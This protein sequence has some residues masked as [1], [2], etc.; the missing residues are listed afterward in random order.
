MVRSM[1]ET[2]L[3]RTV[4]LSVPCADGQQLDPDVF[5]AAASQAAW[6]RSASVV[7]TRTASRIIAVVSVDAPGR[8][9]A[10]AV[11]RAVISDALRASATAISPAPGQLAA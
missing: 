4:T 6:R 11:A 8:Y 10:V 3:P 2:F 5:A 1:D 7:C 9:A